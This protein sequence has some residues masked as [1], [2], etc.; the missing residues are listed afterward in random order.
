MYQTTAKNE[1]CVSYA[2]ETG[3]EFAAKQYYEE[4][5]ELIP[6]VT[7]T[8]ALNAA[9]QGATQ[10]VLLPLESSYH[11]PVSETQQG[12]G[13]TDLSIIGETVVADGSQQRFI[14]L[15]TQIP[16]PTQQDKTSI[17]C[18]TKEQDPGS[19]VRL[20]SPLAYRGISMTSLQSRPDGNGRYSFYIDFEGHQD[21]AKVQEVLQEMELQSTTFKMLGS[22][23]VALSTPNL[24]Q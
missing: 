2:P 4:P 24:L 22:Y 1:I 13:Q 9:E 14:E 5:V 3:A 7:I 12:L 15:G 20:L 17:I 11:G 21:D 10:A 6:K 8:A 16:E 23:P 18:K 19:L